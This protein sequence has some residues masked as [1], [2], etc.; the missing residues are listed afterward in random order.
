MAED[1]VEQRLTHGWL[2]T[3]CWMSI[4]KTPKEFLVPLALQ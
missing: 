4:C 3:I 1:I 2:D